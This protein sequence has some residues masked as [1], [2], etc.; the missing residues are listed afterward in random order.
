MVEYSIGK[1]FGPV[2]SNTDSGAKIR[3]CCRDTTSCIQLLLLET[4]FL[5]IQYANI[6]GIL[7]RVGIS[8]AVLK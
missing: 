3:V 5:N 4:Y 7:A 8:I 1:L 6:L 2:G